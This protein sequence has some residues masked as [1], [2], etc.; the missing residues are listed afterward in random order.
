MDGRTGSGARIH[1]LLEG[2]SYDVKTLVARHRRV[3]LPLERLRRPGHVVDD[4]T[5]LVIES[6]PRSAS[7]FVVAAVRLAQEP[8]STAIAH[9]THMPAQVLEGVRRRLPT[10]VLIREPEAAIVSHLVYRPGLPAAVAVR[11]YVRFHA[12]LE[13]VLDRI[14]VA[15][16]DQAVGDLGAVIARLNERFA[17]SFAPFEHTPANLA[18]IE[19]EIDA[20]ERRRTPGEAVEQKVSRPSVERHAQAEAAR[21][22]LAAVRDGNAWRRATALYVRFAQAAS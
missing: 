20:D 14:V 15:T 12:P 17:T 21:A 18:R 1:G 5:E 7:S 19:G 9:H 22:A 10:L 3:A 11:G 4:A 16:F 8:R 2:A 6:Y 13:R